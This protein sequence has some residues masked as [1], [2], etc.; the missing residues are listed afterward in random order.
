MLCICVERLTH[1]E[2][3]LRAHLLH[4]QDLGDSELHAHVRDR[5]AVDEV[6]LQ[7]HMPAI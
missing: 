1:I 3:L 7:A 2:P 4:Q 5:L 6:L